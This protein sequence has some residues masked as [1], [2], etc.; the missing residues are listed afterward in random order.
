ME[1]CHRARQLAA[2][3]MMAGPRSMAAQLKKRK[4]NST[5][6]L[7]NAGA[8]KINV[9]KKRGITGLGL[10]ESPKTVFEGWRQDQEGVD[11]AEA[12][13]RLKLSWKQLA[14]SLNWPKPF[15]QGAVFAWMKAARS[16]FK[17]FGEASKN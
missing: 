8:S 16:L 13:D 14:Q 11:K 3:V 4:L 1:Y 2:Q 12:E 10:K 6:V 5:F 17:S 7:K 15:D 9:I